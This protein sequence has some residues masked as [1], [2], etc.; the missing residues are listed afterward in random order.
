MK[1]EQAPPP[2]PRYVP[3][4]PQAGPSATARAR[5]QAPMMDGSPGAPSYQASRPAPSAGSGGDGSPLGCEDVLVQP[6]HV[7]VTLAVLEGIQGHGHGQDGHGQERV[8]DMGGSD[9]SAAG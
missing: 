5:G 7:R 4:T 2:S 8:G 3:P 6:V 1:G 9:M